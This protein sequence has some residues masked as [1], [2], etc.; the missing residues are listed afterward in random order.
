MKPAIAVG[1]LL[2]LGTVCFAKGYTGPANPTIPVDRAAIN[3]D[4]ADCVKATE[5]AVGVPEADAPE[6]IKEHAARLCALRARHKDARQRLLAGLAKLVAFFRDQTNHDHAANLPSTI[7]AIQNVVRECVDAVSS[8]QYCHN[9]GCT[10]E[11]E[12]NFILCETKAVEILDTIN[13]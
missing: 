11:P 6:A 3:L 13:P 4:M 2:V 7:K 10:E 5:E 9:V 1:L 8:Q 12:K